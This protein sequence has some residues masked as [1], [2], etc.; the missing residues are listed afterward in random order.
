MNVLNDEDYQLCY[1]SMGFLWKLWNMMKY[2]LWYYDTPSCER[3]CSVEG[4]I[5]FNE[6]LLLW[7]HELQA[8]VSYDYAYCLCI[9]WD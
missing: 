9:M 2:F 4:V 3:K 5:V 1:E 8:Y 6:L 7:S